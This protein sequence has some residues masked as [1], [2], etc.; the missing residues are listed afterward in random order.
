MIGEIK[1]QYEGHKLRHEWKYYINYDTY[2]VL[3]DRLRQII[4]PDENMHDENG[5][6]ISSIYFDDMYGTAMEEKT[7]GTRFR[8]KFRIRSYEYDPGLIRLECKS[9]F[10]EFISKESAKLTQEEYY[11]ILNGDY[12]FLISRPE[13]VCQELFMYHQTKFL[14]PQVTV[15][16]RREAYV[17]PLGN[18]RITFDKD[19]S[20]GT[21]TLDMF[22]EY[23]HTTKI[24]DDDL[25]VLEVKYDDY[26][27]AHIA[28]L[29][30]IG[31]ADQCAI[32][33]YV[34]CRE[35]QRMVKWL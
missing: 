11:K 14:K 12:G 25:M 29:L 6:L 31:M 21:D 27:P 26:L 34:M 23:Y 18:V 19:I 28:K 24:L 33:K 4:G 32:S 13:K 3:R 5:Y 9:K 1:M 15:E 22:S 8:K 16:Y 2:Y 7:A 30:Q 35:K 17:Y 10:D 20:A